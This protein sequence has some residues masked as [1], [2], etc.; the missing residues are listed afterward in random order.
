M[1]SKAAASNNITVHVP[2]GSNIS[3]TYKEVLT[4]LYKRLMEFSNVRF[5]RWT[6]VSPGVVSCRKGPN[7]EVEEKE[8]RRK[9]DGIW[10]PKEKVVRMMIEHVDVL[11]APTPNFE[12]IAQRY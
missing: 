1:K 12:T 3:K 5:S 2:Q 11:P 8:L 7:S 10:T 9:I 6:A 4:E